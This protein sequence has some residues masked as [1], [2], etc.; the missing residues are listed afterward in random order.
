M[1]KAR[2][3]VC[4]VC[5]LLLLATLLLPAS[6]ASAAS[7]DCGK[8]R[9]LVEQAICKDEGLSKLDDRLAEEYKRALSL[10]LKKP[11]LRVDQQRWLETVRNV[12]RDTRCLRRAYVE[13]IQAL[14]ADTQRIQEAKAA[15][16]L[17][18]FALPDDYV[19]FAAGGSGFRRLNFEIDESNF[20]VNQIDV[21][22]HYPSKPVVLMLG[23]NSPTIWNISWSLN[24]RIAGVLVGGFHRQLIA[25]LDPAVPTLDISYQKNSPCGYFSILKSISDLEHLNQV[26]R[27]V[28][29]RVVDRVHFTDHRGSVVV[30][31][32]LSADI[33]L[34]TSSATP[35]ESFFDKTRECAGPNAI[36]DA[37]KKGWV[38]QAT[39]DDIETYVKAWRASNADRDVP[40]VRG[41]EN[42]LPDRPDISDTYVLLRPFRFPC[43]WGR[44]QAPRLIIPK[45]VS[46]APSFP[47]WWIIDLNILRCPEVACRQLD[48]TLGVDAANRS[49]AT[50]N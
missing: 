10:T 38:R 20:A 3:D 7:F 31:E 17:S 35:P 44:Y 43:G 37:V 32:P 39:S 9:T 46:R 42:M 36:E 13:Q 1:R 24:T 29:G 41:R 33:G 48:L 11:E 23:M 26:S 19:I 12:C 6:L 18:G 25:G 22:V 16:T 49:G 47:G 2:R 34:L 50:R 14:A 45:G 30:G 27:H 40:Q 21:A 4:R 5:K 15:C 28:F 8:A